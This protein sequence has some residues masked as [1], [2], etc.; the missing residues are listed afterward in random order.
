MQPAKSVISF[1]E[2]LN[3][4][5]N[6]LRSILTRGLEWLTAAVFAALVINVLWGVLTRYLFGDQARW[7]EELARLL[8]VWLVFLGAVLSLAR[9]EH[10]GVDLLLLK[11]HP[12]VRPA[13]LLCVHAA[14]LAFSAAVLA[15]GGLQ[16][17]LQR[18]E[19]GQTLPALGISKSW[20]YLA[21]PISGL[22]MSLVVVESGLRHFLKPRRDGGGE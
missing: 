17:T 1:A 18:W 21:I 4:R 11:L 14:V 19:S 5:V 6:G 20:F 7:S 12:E 15:Y 2:S 3:N 9:Q 16:L 13:A 22:F 8:M 10:L